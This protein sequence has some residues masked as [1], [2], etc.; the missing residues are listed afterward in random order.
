MTLSRK[1][2]SGEQIVVI[3]MDVGAADL[4]AFRQRSVIIVR[5]DW[6]DEKQGVIPKK[7]VAI[8]CHPDH[9]AKFKKNFPKAERLFRGD[10]V[11][12]RSLPQLQKFVDARAGQLDDREFKYEPKEV[13]NSIEIPKQSDAQKIVEQANEIK[14]LDTALVKANGKIRNLEES[15]RDLE[16]KNLGLRTENGSLRRRLQKVRADEGSVSESRP[17]SF[18]DVLH[19]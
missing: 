5:P 12:S 11:F 4:D 3:G 13:K 9:E 17:E 18:E 14:R 19:R 15:I 8:W 1:L 7:F 10:L 16:K 6:I 2:L